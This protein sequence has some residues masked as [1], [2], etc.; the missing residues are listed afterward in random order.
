MAGIAGERRGRSRLPELEEQLQF[1]DGSNHTC[2]T[3]RLG[4]TVVVDYSIVAE[5]SE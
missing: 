2:S 5:G 4:G 3:V 1:G